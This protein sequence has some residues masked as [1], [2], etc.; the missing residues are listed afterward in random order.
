M[1][2]NK[3]DDIIMGW[4]LRIRSC[5]IKLIVCCSHVNKQPLMSKYERDK[6]Y[7]N[8]KDLICFKTKRTNTKKTYIAALN[9]QTEEFERYIKKD[10]GYSYNH[11]HKKYF[12]MYHILH[13]RYHEHLSQQTQFQIRTW[14]F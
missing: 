8:C 4:N 5:E 3:S 14:H 9:K 13:I 1:K 7:E 12:E 6:L 11:I 10:E 2:P